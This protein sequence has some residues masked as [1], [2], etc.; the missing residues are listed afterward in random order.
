MVKFSDVSVKAFADW[1]IL[2]ERNFRFLKSKYRAGSDRSWKNFIR[3]TNLYHKTLQDT[4]NKKEALAAVYERYPNVV[5]VKKK[6]WKPTHGNPTSR[7]GPVDFMRAYSRNEV[8]DFDEGLIP[9]AIKDWYLD[10]ESDV[11]DF[12]PYVESDEVHTDS[13][14]ED[15]S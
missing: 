6:L 11:S 13:E 12:E 5:L 1:K 7:K 8:G 10:E 3:A 9:K 14:S 15:T 4:N 2:K